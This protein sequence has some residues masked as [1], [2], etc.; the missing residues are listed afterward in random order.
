MADR[1]AVL[2][3]LW[4]IKSQIKSVN[5]NFSCTNFIKIQIRSCGLGKTVNY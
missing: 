5:N 2:G 3:V 4:L 1:V